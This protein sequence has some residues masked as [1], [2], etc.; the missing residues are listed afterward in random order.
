MESVIR[1]VASVNNPAN[2]YITGSTGESDSQFRTRRNKAMSVPTQG[3]DE[4]TESQMLDLAD[5]IDCKV[6]D[7]RTNEEVNGIPAHGIWVIVEGGEPEE[8]GEIIY[9]N[10]PPGIPMKGSQTVLVSKV[11]GDTET[12]LYDVPTPTNLYVKATIR[13][14]TTSDIDTGFIIQELSKN[15]Y[16]IGE[17]AESVNLQTQIKTLIGE[18]GT[19]YDVLISEDNKSWV[20]YLAPTALDA[21]FT[22]TSETVTLEVVD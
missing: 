19:P 2:N 16:S 5:V 15:V 14:F 4:S 18:S 22:I 6:Y 21:Y 1:G 3:F 7:N 12:I 13:N 10:L 20:E 17:Q 8:I 11:N 9:N